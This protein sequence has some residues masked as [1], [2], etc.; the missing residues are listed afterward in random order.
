[1]IMIELIERVLIIL[2]NT[3]YFNSLT[4]TSQ[5]IGKAP[6]PHNEVLLVFVQSILLK[7]EEIVRRLKTS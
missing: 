2:R 7:Q 5:A 6:A 4:R 1:M 3:A